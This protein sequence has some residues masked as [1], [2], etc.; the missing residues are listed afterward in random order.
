MKKN[1]AV[2]IV[3]VV[4]TLA[5]L[6][7]WYI[8]DS[9]TAHSEPKESITIGTTPLEAYAL[10]FIAQD[11]GIFAK[12]GIN[13]TIRYYDTA[14]PAVHGMESGDVDISTSS[15][16]PIVTEAFKKEN[17]SIIGSIDKYHSFT[18][19][20][21]RDRGIKNVSDLEG[22]KIGFI[23]RGS[24]AEF[25]L[26]RLLDLHGMSLQDVAIV[27]I[28]PS[29]SVNAIANGDID[30]IQAR[31][32][33]VGSIRERLGNNCVTLS[34]QNDQET[35][36]VLA[37]R[38]DW[39]EAHPKTINRL[40]KSLEQ[41]EG[42]AVNHPDVAK[43]ILQKRLNFT[44]K[45]MEAA[46]PEHQYSLTL[47]QSLLIAMNDEGRWMMNNIITTEKTL[48]YFRDYIYTKSLEV[49]KPGAVNIR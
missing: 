23:Q 25:Y 48:P 38:N 42:Y 27:N 44:D 47:D 19:L 29:Q 40:L 34:S 9:P 43:S 41:A 17:I 37:C 10:I 6:G 16:Y 32:D 49:V 20:G 26:G 22:K 15:E 18:L 5:G 36:I 14:V 24:I 39:A 35:F 30:A 12:N 45:Y 21:R 11:L 13:A 2:M 4:I 46:W 3:I 1:A 28:T 8:L 7:A 31:N 33:Y